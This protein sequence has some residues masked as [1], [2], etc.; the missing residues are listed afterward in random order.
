MALEIVWR[1]SIPP[2]KT[3]KW[4]EPIAVD[5]FGALY[6]VRTAAETAAFEVILGGAA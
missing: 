4:V 3:E 5:N 1:N 6:V 2:A